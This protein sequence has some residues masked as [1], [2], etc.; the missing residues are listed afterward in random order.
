MHGTRYECLFLTLFAVSMG[1][2]LHSENAPGMLESAAAP[3]PSCV[4][5]I[6]DGSETDIDCG[7]SGSC[8]AC[9]DYQSCSTG[10]DCTSL[11]CANAICQPVSC[12][13]GVKNDSESGVDCGAPSC[14]LCGPG[15][16]CREGADC[17]S[18]V[19][20]AGVCEG[21]S[22]YDGVRNGEEADVDCGP[23]CSVPCP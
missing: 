1:C 6:K 8:P 14:P 7:G 19:C 22:C 11:V 5:G 15:Q 10:T 13:D 12:S 17:A 21:P 9:A 4:D 18:G 3:V 23:A 20:W 2:T 16:G